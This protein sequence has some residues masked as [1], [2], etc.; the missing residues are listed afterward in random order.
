MDAQEW[1]ESLN[2][3]ESILVE[4]ID[5]LKNR[6]RLLQPVSATTPLAP[7]P[8]VAL[9]TP[10]F[11]PSPILNYHHQP[12]NQSSPPEQVTCLSP[13]LPQ[14]PQEVVLK[15][16]PSTATSPRHQTPQWSP[17]PTPNAAPFHHDNRNS[18]VHNKA[19]TEGKA[20]ERKWCPL[21][22]PVET[23]PN[24]TSKTEW[25]SLWSFA[26]T[27]PNSNGSTEWRPPWC[28]PEIGPDFILEDKDILSGVD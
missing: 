25:W 24:A 19:L 14:T 13:L 7:S 2:R 3:I 6:T 21:W 9:P 11:L 17:I 22:R 5:F 12:L 18:L 4:I 10:V 20:K 1:N 16:S 26:S 15:T 8:V 23:A 27:S 28:I